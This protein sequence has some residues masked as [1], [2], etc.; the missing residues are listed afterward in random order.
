LSIGVPQS[1]SWLHHPASGHTPYHFRFWVGQEAPV[2]GP[3]TWSNTGTIASPMECSPG[4]NDENPGGF[5]D[6]FC[7]RRLQLGLIAAG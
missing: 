4:R 6:P 1:L 3:K 2:D 5:V 7:V